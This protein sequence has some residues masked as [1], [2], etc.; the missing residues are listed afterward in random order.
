M[1][2]HTK[3][4]VPSSAPLQRRHSSTVDKNKVSES[5][6]G[7]ACHRVSKSNPAATR[8]AEAPQ[9]STLPR[10]VPRP[11]DKSHHS[12]SSK[13]PPRI[14]TKSH[15]STSTKSLESGTTKSHPSALSKTH[16]RIT[17]EPHHFGPSKSLPRP[18]NK[19]DRSAP[20]PPLT[21]YTTFR[22]Q[23]PILVTPI[24]GTVHT[25]LALDANFARNVQAWIYGHVE[26]V[27]CKSKDEKRFEYHLH[28]EP[29]EERVE[30]TEGMRRDLMDWIDTDDEEGGVPAEMRSDLM[31]YMDADD[32]E[33]SGMKIVV[34][35]NSPDKMTS[36]TATKIEATKTIKT[37]DVKLE[38]IRAKTT[39]EMRSDLVSWIE[40]DDEDI[41]EG[42]IRIVVTSASPA[43]MMTI[44]T[45]EYEAIK[46]IKSDSR[47]KSGLVAGSSAQDEPVNP[48]AQTIARKIVPAPL[49]RLKAKVATPVAQQARL[50]L[51]RTS[52]SLAALMAI[53]HDSDDDGERESD[54]DDDDC[55]SLAEFQ[56][57][58]GGEEANN[59]V[60]GSPAF[61]QTGTY[62][63][64]VKKV[65][66]SLADHLT[67]TR[68]TLLGSAYGAGRLRTQVC[69]FKNTIATQY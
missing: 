8:M 23:K 16:P 55:D 14:T 27:T 24:R 5:A 28:L 3:I 54:D 18:T 45:S 21:K 59:A 2:P 61:F 29:D 50:R 36:I 15:R 9:Q 30:V 63:N 33:E 7:P 52:P 10:S 60:V 40:E 20:S 38:T 1:A 64:A 66:G 19:P 32:E 62:A 26:D 12:A 68:H 51:R 58:I 37:G 17:N 35:P 31:A 11:N 53:A 41:E 34:T 69:R 22:R 4:P 67:S 56:R 57:E 42:G 39:E 48:C 46:A 13:A 6:S 65:S 44:T 43:K 25:L 49:F 47:E